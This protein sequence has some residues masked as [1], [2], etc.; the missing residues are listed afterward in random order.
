MARSRIAGV[1][2]VF[3]VDAETAFPIFSAL[4]P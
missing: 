3:V 4:L 1:C 2:A